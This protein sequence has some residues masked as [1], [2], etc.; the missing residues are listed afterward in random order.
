MHRFAFVLLFIAASAASAAAQTARDLVRASIDAVGGDERL[1][2][3]HAIE[4]KGIGHRYGL[5]QSERPEGPWLV[6]YEQV[7]DILDFDR[8][9][10][11]E[12][13][14]ARGYETP[15]WDSSADW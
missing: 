5:E 1:R 14:D 6:Q 3:I 13:I 12:E 4:I 10:F 15:N 2:A 7:D 8:Q 9:R 11:R